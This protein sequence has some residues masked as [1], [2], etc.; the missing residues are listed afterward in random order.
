M[1]ATAVDVAICALDQLGTV[2][3]MKLQKLVFYS[4]AL[5][6]VEASTPLFHERIEAWR[7]GPVVPELFQRHSGQFVIS[8]GF[9]GPSAPSS[10][11]ADQQHFIVRTVECF[12]DYS[13]N[14]LSELTH[15][16]GPWKDA[17]RGLAPMDAGRVEITGEAI[18]RFYGSPACT[19][20]LF[21]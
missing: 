17:R 20:P 16:E 10:L 9:F 4:Q 2:S 18:K 3:T 8:A 1:M 14:D 7:N 19:N 21:V 12:K 5:S 6:L 15:S 11:D 13:G